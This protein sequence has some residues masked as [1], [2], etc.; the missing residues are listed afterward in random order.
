QT[1]YIKM[2]SVYIYA[3]LIGTLGLALKSLVIMLRESA[4][5]H[6]SLAL[7]LNPEESETLLFKVLNSFDLFA[8]WQYA[9]L[10]IGF[11]VIYKFTIKKAGI[12]MAVLFLITVVITVG[13]SQIF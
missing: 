3:S 8:I 1:T 4:D 6:F 11:A 13:L 7:L 10:A 9:V 12:T 2:F 5:V